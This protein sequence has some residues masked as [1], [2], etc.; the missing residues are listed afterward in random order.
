M[1]CRWSLDITRSSIRIKQQIFGEIWMKKIGNR[2]FVAL[3]A[4][5]GHEIQQRGSLRIVAAPFGLG[6]VVRGTTGAEAS[7]RCQQQQAIRSY[8]Q[9]GLARHRM[10][11]THLSLAYSQNVLL[12]TMVHFNLPAIKAGLHQQFGRSGQIG[13]EK[14]SRLA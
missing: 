10:L 5:Q 9:R 6:Q 7:Q 14:V 13:S 1:P 11:A 2:R 8:R 12:I 4:E 3:S